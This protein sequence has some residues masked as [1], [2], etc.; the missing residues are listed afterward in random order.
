MDQPAHFSILAGRLRQNAIRQLSYLINRPGVINFSGGV[1]SPETFPYQAIAEIT[2]RLVREQ[3]ASVLQYGVT[4]GNAT[5]IEQV[6]EYMSAKGVKTDTRQ[7]LLTSGS[8]Q[9]LDLIS[10][11]LIDPG[12][13]VLVE[14]PSYIGGLC[15]LQMAGAEIIGVPL[16]EDGLEIDQLIAQLSL[17]Q[18][19]GRR[20]KL[21]YTIPNFQNPSGITLA[22][23]KRARLLEL[24]AEYNLIILE[25]DPYGELYFDDSQPTPTPLKSLDDKGLVVYLGSFSKVLSPGLRTAWIVAPHEIAALIETAKEATDLC[26]SVFDQAVVSECYRTNLIQGRLA[27]LRA[28]YRTRA[29]AM[30]TTLA[31]KA[32]A[33]C[34]WTKPG[35]GLF[36]WMQL[37]PHISASRLL[38]TAVEEGVAFVP[39]RPFYAN[40]SKD[41]VLRLA[42]SKETPERITIG[43][44][45]LCAL[46]KE[47]V[48]ER[49]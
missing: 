46:I 8:Q 38:S 26:S 25:D 11:I 5:L 42:F 30:L 48:S 41:N 2:A 35:G 6:C 7:I 34:H 20:V 40:E 4:R 33:D 27:E 44:T 21:L 13:V 17:L 14:D 1:P 39:G 18:R 36:V 3:G 43:I 15:A 32:P 31:A 16:A 45:K 19:A 9:G 12:D 23:E 49:G 22:T 10:R 28:F 29:K 47:T 37:A 24:A